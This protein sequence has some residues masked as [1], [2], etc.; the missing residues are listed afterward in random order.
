MHLVHMV[1]PI[2]RT[3]TNMKRFISLLALSTVLLAVVA[4]GGEA[5]TEPTATATVAPTTTA[6]PLPIREWN[7]EDI[8]VDGSTVTVSL[9]VFAG[10][11][12]WATLDDERADEVRPAIPTIEYVFLNVTPGQ[13]TVEVQ[14]VVGHNETAEVLVPTISARE[15]TDGLCIPAAPLGVSAGDRWALAGTVVVTGPFPG[16]IPQG[17][18]GQ[19]TSFTVTAIEDSTLGIGD[20]STE[21]VPYQ[22]V[23]V[24]STHTWNDASGNTLSTEDAELGGV[25]IS[26]GNQGTVLTLDWECHRAAWL[27]SWQTPDEATVEQRTLPSGVT[28]VVFSVTQAFDIPTQGLAMTVE[29]GIGYD[30]QT[31]R[32]VF[33]KSRT[34]GT[35]NG[36]A[37]SVVMDQELVA[38]GTNLPAWLNDLTHRLQNEPVAN[39]PALIAQYE[40]N[41]Q[42]VYF[43]PQ[44]CCDIFSDLY[45]DDGN[46]IGHPDGGITGRGDGRVPD[47]FEVRSNENVV[48]RDLRAY[49]SSQIQVP[50]PIESVDLIIMESFPPQYSLEVVSGLPNSCVS[51]GGYTMTRDGDT[52]RVEVTNLEPANL[53]AMLCA[54]IY[55]T[56]QTVIPLGSDFEPDTSYTVDVNGTTVSL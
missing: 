54:E 30:V 40:Y 8:Q 6:T 46:I 5:A 20:R 18:A 36:E 33:S 23:Q 2:E 55:R 37:F 28:A 48:W 10:I 41:G 51:Y 34:T 21:P 1:N 52:I 39:P 56:V 26:V 24:Q 53:S 22:R 44:R 38:D 49:D 16:E 45:D 32:L 15:P 43:L 4:C 31:G 29:R 7:V 50:A 19:S 42:T 13:H 25:T 3:R 47:L 9:H 14:D 27:D 35:L 12:V 11:D 17:A